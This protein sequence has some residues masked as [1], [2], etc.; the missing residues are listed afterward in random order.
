VLIAFRDSSAAL[1]VS[2]HYL[3]PPSL[4]A[5]V[6]SHREMVISITSGRN[7]LTTALPYL[8]TSGSRNQ[9]W[10]QKWKVEVF[11]FL[12]FNERFG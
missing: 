5:D 3:N 12:D 6:G 4:Q 10:K 8:G 9:R 7:I 11:Y 2:R 1:Q